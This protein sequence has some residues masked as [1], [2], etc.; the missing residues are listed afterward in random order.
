MLSKEF[1]NQLQENGFTKEQTDF[2]ISEVPKEVKKNMAYKIMPDRPHVVY[3]SERN[4]YTFYKIQ[5]L[6]K[7]KENNTKKGYKNVVFNGCEAPKNNGERIMIKQCYEDFYY[8][9][10]DIYNPVFILVIKDYEYVNQKEHEALED[11]SAILEYK[12]NLDDN[13]DLPF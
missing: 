4:G 3:I 9:P 13:F 6:K 10:K 2:L 1:I 7:D 12:N 11:D 8:K 5:V